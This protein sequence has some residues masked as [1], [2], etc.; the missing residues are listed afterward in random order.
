MGDLGPGRGVRQ[1]AGSTARAAEEGRERY[2]G[3]VRRPPGRPVGLR[4][5]SRPEF[6]SIVGPRMSRRRPGSPVTVAA[7]DALT[8]AD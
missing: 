3:C 6:D 1:T 4:V 5:A 8:L 2:S 7:P